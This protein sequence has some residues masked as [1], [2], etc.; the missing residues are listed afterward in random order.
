MGNQKRVLFVCT[1]NAARSQMAEAIVNHSR[2]NEWRA[3]SAGTHP[4]PAIHPNAIRV[5]K[6][7]GIDISGA[8]TKS[9]DEF[10]DAGLDLVVTV[11]DSAAEECPG[12]LGEGKRVHVGFTDPAKMT[13]TEDE[14]VSAFRQVR[15]EMKREIL[16]TLEAFEQHESIH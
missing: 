4:K 10:R 9:V 2:G 13:G 11:C 8:R 3:F 15:D 16:A 6:E 7:I 5:L 1:G 12:W 14:I